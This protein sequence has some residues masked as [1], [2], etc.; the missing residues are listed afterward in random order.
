MRT[1]ATIALA[2]TLAGCATPTP[3]P[4]TTADVETICE[5]QTL[6]EVEPGSEWT[7]TQ[8]EEDVLDDGSSWAVYGYW[9]QPDGSEWFA[10][11]YAAWVDGDLATEVT[12][13][14]L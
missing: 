9:T 8:T 14:P 5:A 12:V 2:L 11:C 7:H 10:E 3:E 6:G 4:P 1:A 13:S